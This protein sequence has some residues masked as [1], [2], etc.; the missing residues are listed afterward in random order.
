MTPAQLAR[1]IGLAWA[2]GLGLLALGCTERT[3]LL[4]PVDAGPMACSGLGA[5]VRLG[6]ADGSC[7]GALAAVTL[8]R[9]LCSCD[10][11]ILPGNLATESSGAGGQGP[12]P[13]PGGPPSTPA[14]DVA[15]DGSIEIGG[16]AQVAGSISA[17]ASD[18]I[19]FNRAA[20]IF[21]G[22]RSGGSLVAE[23]LVTVGADAYVAGDVLGRVDVG[24]TLYVSPS[25]SVSPPASENYIVREEI[26]VEPPCN[27][28]VGPVVDVDALVSVA[29]NHND[30]VAGG[31][32][33]AALTS[34]HGPTVF[35]LPCGSYFL[36]S[37]TSDDT[38]Q[39][40]VHGRSALYIDGDLDL[41]DGLRV[42]L[43][44]GAELDLF[45]TG[46]VSLQAGQLGA[47]SPAAVRLW[48]ASTV[49]QLGADASLS[50][51]VY[52]PNATVLPQQDLM[53][54]GALFVGA[55][56][57]SGDVTVRFDSNVLDDGATCD[58]TTAAADLGSP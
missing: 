38:L 9:A 46:D 29:A 15:S 5:P 31:V 25:S 44:S 3:D 53:A 21:G 7:A 10:S 37:L 42:T 50:A 28:A 2:L 41:A 8:S 49:I 4:P 56:A 17:G 52:A 55:I 39:V 36:P 43:D 48:L 1:T 14:A 58:G 13:S 54:S 22:L 23:Q 12:G 27:C 45:V 16:N 40:R 20:S 34:T 19:G 51:I 26:A 18:G 57:A 24:G 33:V 35:D 47:S 30:N 32:D 11:I 6:G